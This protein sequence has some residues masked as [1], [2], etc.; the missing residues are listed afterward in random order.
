MTAGCIRCPPGH[1]RFSNMTDC[2]RALP[3]MYMDDHGDAGG[4]T[5]RLLR[6]QPGLAQASL[7]KRSLAYLLHNVRRFI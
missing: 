7:R 1:Y 4:A 5:R 3:G 6:D 2:E